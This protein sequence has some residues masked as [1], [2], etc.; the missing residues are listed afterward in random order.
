MASEKA[1][2]SFE[3]LRQLGLGY[4]LTQALGFIRSC[5]NQDV[6][7]LPFTLSVQIWIAIGRSVLVSI[8]SLEKSRETYACA[9]PKMLVTIKRLWMIMLSKA[10]VL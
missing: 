10:I 3:K 8:V 7:K 2:R 6:P 5:Q 4:K 1:D 9:V